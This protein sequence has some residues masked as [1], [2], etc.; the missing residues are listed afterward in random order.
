MSWIN[1]T[2][3]GRDVVLA[4]RIRIARNIADI[5][6][7]SAMQAHHAA[8]V[9]ENV[10]KSLNHIRA[11]T[12]S[13]FAFM[14]IRD[15]PVV[16][17]QILVEKHLASQDLMQNHEVSALCWIRKK[18]CGMI[19]EEDHIRAQCILPGFQLNQ[20]WEKLNHVDNII[21]RIW[22][23]ISR[24]AC[25]LTCCPTNVGT[26]MRSSVMMHLPALT[27][28]KQMNAILQTISKVGLTARGTERA[29]K[30]LE[31]FIRYPTKSPRGRRRRN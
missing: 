4:S 13:S 28:N 14:Y 26:G 8:E 21:E 3:P 24:A 25:Y 6:F 31:A 23:C 29:A 5:P 22:V 17:R 19:N 20:A 11:E 16:E 30:P 10:R 18:N 1:E 9:A 2:G 12:G 15:V 7:P 27:A